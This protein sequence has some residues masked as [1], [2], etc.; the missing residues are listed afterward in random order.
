MK[1]DI[2]TLAEAKKF[3]DVE[4]AVYAD[5]SLIS[6]LVKLLSEK[7]GDVRSGVLTLLS[8]VGFDYPNDTRPH[9]PTLIAL[10]DD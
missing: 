2:K 3:G 6:D 10:L 7:N 4:T 8:R 1:P 9:L 5:R